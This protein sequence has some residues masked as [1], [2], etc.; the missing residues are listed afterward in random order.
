MSREETK[1]II[2]I[3]I[4][5]YPHYKPDDMQMTLVAWDEMLRDYDYRTVAVALKTFI[6]TDTSGFAP[7]IGQII[8]NIAKVTVPSSMGESEAW[9][10]VRKAIENGAY[11]SQR[12]F[13]RLPGEI[14]KAVGSANQIHAWAID[15]NYNEG[16][17]SSNF[18][19]AYR[20]ECKR[21]EEYNRMPK[22]IRA[23][24]EALNGSERV[25]I[26]EKRGL[27]P[28]EKQGDMC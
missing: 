1:K 16:V 11:N 18:M 10:L 23:R 14:Q 13:D 19:R 24:I 4:A 9:A 7:S 6:A 17:I 26:D 25:M 2:A 3:M 28:S 22:D 27:L 20:T 21:Q 12:E 15:E 5:S 8:D